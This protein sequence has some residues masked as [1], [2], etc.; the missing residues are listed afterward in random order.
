MNRCKPVEVW[1]IP[2]GTPGHWCLVRGRHTGP[3][4]RE[5]VLPIPYPAEVALALLRRHAPEPAPE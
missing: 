1:A 3:S 2:A 5:D 4:Y